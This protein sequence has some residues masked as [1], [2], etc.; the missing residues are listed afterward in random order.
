[1]NGKGPSL[2]KEVHLKTGAA[3]DE[4]IRA[5]G[6]VFEHK[7]GIRPARNR[8]TI[9]ATSGYYTVRVDGGVEVFYHDVSRSTKEAKRRR[10]GQ[11]IDR[12]Q[13]ALSVEFGERRVCTVTRHSLRGCRVAL[14]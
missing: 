5:V 1:M 11:I 12:A 14:T 2:T 8:G 9:H 4:L 7:L 13:R 6:R 3:T 10:Q